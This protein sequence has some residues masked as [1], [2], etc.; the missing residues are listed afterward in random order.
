V[1]VLIPLMALMALTAIAA[2]QTG[3]ADDGPSLSVEH[4]VDLTHNLTRDF[5][6]NPVSGVYYPFDMQVQTL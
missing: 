5:P 3:P 2:P 6:Y 1:G 4:F